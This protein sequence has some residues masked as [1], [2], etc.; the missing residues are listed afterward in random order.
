[1]K[2]EH[3]AFNVSDVFAVS[4]WWS[5]N[6]GM[7]IVVAGSV[8]PYMHFLSDDQGSMLE[9]YSNTAAPIPD[10]SQMDPFNLHFAY[11]TLDIAADQ[12]RL[13]AAGA[14]LVSETLTPAGDKLAFL[15]DP[16]QIPFQLVQRK[17]PLL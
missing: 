9:I 10:Y 15:R 14:T 12:A 3:V 17:K 7:R 2:L 5:E 13:I 16:H 6:L 8:A 11:S 4:K 1:M